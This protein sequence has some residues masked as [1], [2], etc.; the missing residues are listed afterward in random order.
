LSQDADDVPTAARHVVDIDIAG[1]GGSW[2]TGRSCRSLTG[3]PTGGLGLWWLEL[4]RRGRAAIADAPE[5][6]G[7]RG[8]R[9]WF[10]EHDEYVV[11]FSDLA[12]PKRSSNP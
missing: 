1:H 8:F 12:Q 4:A 9:G 2:G 3:G 11:V 10:T 5:R 6:P 7:L